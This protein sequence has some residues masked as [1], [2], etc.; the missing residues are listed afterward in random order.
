ML[1]VKILSV[2]DVLLIRK[3]I[4]RVVESL[5]GDL[6]EAPDGKD[7]LKVLEENYKDIDLIILDWNMPGMNGFDFLKAVKNN[8]RFKHIPI[9][10]ATTENEKEKIIRAIQAGAS[11]YLSKPFTEQELSKK[12]LDS[13]GLGYERFLNRCICSAVC[14]SMA[15]ITGSTKILEMDNSGVD[16]DDTG[17]FWGQIFIFGQINAIAYLTMSQETALKIVPLVTPKTSSDLTNEQGID[18]ISELLNMIVVKTKTLFV[19]SG[20]QL[21]IVNSFIMQGILKEKAKVSHGKKRFLI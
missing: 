4:R 1:V 21:N 7:A 2:D 3:L 18:G 8:V 19:G 14:D 17:C 11:N 16:V 13:L 5:G 6:L 15:T 20:I 12:I 10:M 9:I